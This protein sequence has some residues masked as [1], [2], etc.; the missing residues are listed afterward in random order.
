MSQPNNPFREDSRG[1]LSETEFLAAIV[2]GSHDAIV[3]KTLEGVITSW[4]RGA[5]HMYGYAAA[6]AIGQVFDPFFTTKGHGR[7]T[8]LGLATVVRN[9]TAEWR[10]DRGNQRTRAWRHFRYLS[11]ASRGMCPDF[12]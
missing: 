7:G 1:R 9:R 4:N 11:A 10:G 3:R 2:E 6:E 8:G 5:E 12:L